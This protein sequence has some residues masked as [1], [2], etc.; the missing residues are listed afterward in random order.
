M[1][2]LKLLAVASAAIVLGTAGAA[3]GE[4]AHVSSAVTIV[5]TKSTSLGTILV[6][7]SGKTLYADTG[8]CTGGCLQIWPPLAAKGKLEAKGQ[9]HAAMLG[10][11]HGQ[12]TYHG[13][14]LY[15]FVSDA[16]G[17]SGEGSN[18]FFVV[19]PSGSLI[20]KAPRSTSSGSSSSSGSAW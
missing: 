4:S 13:H 3:F 11:S 20:T 14:L 8:S 7:G 16:T 1:K 10:K 2:Q 15:T 17:T 12:V 6:T 9:A 19:S 18:G 5:K